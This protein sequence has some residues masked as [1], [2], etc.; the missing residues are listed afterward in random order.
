MIE[1]FNLLILNKINLGKIWEIPFGVV[2]LVLSNK[3]TPSLFNLCLVCGM[4]SYTSK[5]RILNVLWQIYRF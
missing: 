1:I 3:I 5:R 4:N 2:G